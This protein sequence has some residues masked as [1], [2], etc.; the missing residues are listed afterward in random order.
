MG[1]HS[2][3]YNDIAIQSISKFMFELDGRE[4]FGDMDFSQRLF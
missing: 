2:T 1:G 4:D 3:V